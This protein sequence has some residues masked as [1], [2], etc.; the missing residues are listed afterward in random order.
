MARP[1]PDL[2]DYQLRDPPIIRQHL[3][4]L[5]FIGPTIQFFIGWKLYGEPMTSSRLASFAL[6]W[7]AV[8]IYAADALK[9]AD[10]LAHDLGCPHYIRVPALGTDPIFIEAL[11]ELAVG[12][13]GRTGTAPCQ[14]WSCEARHVKCP[15]RKT[16]A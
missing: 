4:I 8:A 6:I 14:G 15:H 12:S 16:A 11:S 13:L 1:R 5:Q 7:L 2:P 9:R 3:G 10:E